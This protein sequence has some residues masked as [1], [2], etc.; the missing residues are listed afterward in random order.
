M[1]NQYRLYLERIDPARNM[2]RFYILAIEKSLF[3]EL[4]LTRRWGRIGTYGREATEICTSEC[5][6]LA[7]LLA[8]A[9]T[10]RMRHYRLAS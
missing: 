2:R 9:R 7:R 5:D 8:V 10:K 3:G 4:L 6:A 1:N